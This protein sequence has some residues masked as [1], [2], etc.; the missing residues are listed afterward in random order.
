M[1]RTN[2][3]GRQARGESGGRLR[4]AWTGRW[5]TIAP[6]AGLI[7]IV[8]VAG[9]AISRSAQDAPPERLASVMHVDAVNATQVAGYR[10]SREFVGRVEARRESLLSFELAGLVTGVTVDEGDR[11]ERGQVVGTLDTQVLRAQRESIAA[12]WQAARSLLDEMVAGPRVEV[13]AAARADVEQWRARTQLASITQI[14]NA[15]LVK[16]NVGSKQE[17]D[18]ATYGEQSIRAQLKAAQSRLSELENGTRQ[19]QLASQQASVNQLAAELATI[20]VRIAKSDL[21]APYSGIIAERFVDEGTVVEAGA[22]VV[23]LL[24]TDHLEVRVGV[25]EEAVKGLSRGTVEEVYVHGKA[26]AAVVRSVRPDRD[27]QTRTV[28]VLLEL[29]P[30]GQIVRVGD[31]ATVRFDGG[32]DQPGFWLPISALAEGYRG[33]WGCYVAESVGGPLPAT[34]QLRLRELEVIHQTSDT[35]FVRGSLEEGELVVQTGLQRL[36]P[37]QLVQ[38]RNIRPTK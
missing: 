30:S 22:A 27:Q 4:Q 25:S 32:V 1:I 19:E 35:A 14:R 10:V 31:L 37:G 6:M 21:H 28:S 16:E 23:E 26:I 33:L 15:R 5:G 24:E 3:V 38:L 12:E 36:V 34:H 11:V 8:L 7:V 9:G 17:L 20:D 18:D 13:I 2:D 29:K